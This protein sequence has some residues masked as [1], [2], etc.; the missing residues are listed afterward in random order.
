[1][2]H[3]QFSIFFFFFFLVAKT[4]YYIWKRNVKLVPDI[5]LNGLINKI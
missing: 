3:H 1:M 4:Q 2:A 5:F